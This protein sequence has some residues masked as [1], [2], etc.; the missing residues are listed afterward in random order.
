MSGYYLCDYYLGKE[1][2]TYKLPKPESIDLESININDLDNLDIIYV[3]FNYFDKFCREIL[4]RVRVKIILITGQL[5]I[6]QIQKSDLTESI[7][8]NENVV[9]WISQNPI[10]RTQDHNKY[11]AFPY[12]IKHKSLAKYLRVFNRYP[13]IKENT[14][15]LGYINQ[16]THP[17]RKRLPNPNKQKRMGYYRHISHSKFFISP[18]GDRD[19]THRHYEC[20]GLG[21]LPISDLNRNLYEQLF[22]DNM[23]YKDIDDCVAIANSLHYPE[24]EYKEPNRNFVTMEYWKEYLSRLRENCQEMTYFYM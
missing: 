24:S 2:I 3:Q 23:I 12:G 20:I 18:R 9:Y 8:N 21:T 4:P 17:D 19:D 11:I 16:G 13:Y 15:A 14:V 7:I 6:P 22:G 10:Y 5:H 1:I